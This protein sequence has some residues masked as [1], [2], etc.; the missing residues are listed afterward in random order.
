MDKRIDAIIA[1][2]RPYK[3]VSLTIENASFSTTPLMTKENR[4]K[5]KKVIGN[6]KN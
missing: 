4:P 3:C 5:L 2:K 6:E 1:L